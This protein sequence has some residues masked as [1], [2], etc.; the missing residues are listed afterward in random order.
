MQNKLIKEK[1]DEIS[2]LKQAYLT[3]Q[4]DCENILKLMYDDK[5]KICDS[6]EVLK[7]LKDSLCCI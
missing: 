7:Q 2:T 6:K 3:V 5:K 1:E 4:L